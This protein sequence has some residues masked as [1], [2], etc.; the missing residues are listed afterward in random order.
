MNVA[1]F[2]RSQDLKQPPKLRR[3]L[4]RSS[5][6][7]TN[8]LRCSKSPGRRRTSS[9]RDIVQEVYDRMGVNYVRGQNSPR[10]YDRNTSFSANSEVSKLTTSLSSNVSRA[11]EVSTESFQNISVDTRN[12]V[13]DDTQDR[14]SSRSS[15]SVR[16]LM[17]VFGGGKSVAS[18]KSVSSGNNFR[19]H[20]FGIANE[21]VREKIIDCHDDG[22]MDGTMSVISLESHWTCKKKPHLEVEDKLK[23]S[24]SRSFFQTST[25]TGVAV[26][27][28]QN[29]AQAV[30]KASDGLSDSD[31]A[32]DK[33]IEEKLQAKLAE[34]TASFDEKL[35]LLD[36]ETNRRLEKMEKELKDSSQRKNKLTYP[37]QHHRL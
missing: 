4:T 21:G 23:A 28:P 11:K 13:S 14:I 9:S 7:T 25:S 3:S 34:L 1:E 27:K 6:E 15:R 8:N 17:S 20:A 24:R 2:A 37:Y 26:A 32:I 31:E 33:F 12:E 36:E 29:I 22:D 19:G 18:A 5:I 10:I 16:S 35:R 30:P